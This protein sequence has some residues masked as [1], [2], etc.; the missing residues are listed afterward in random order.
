[1]LFPTT[2]FAVFFAIVFGVYWA[3][4]RF[5]LPRKVF[6]LGASVFFYAWWSW[7]FALMMLGVAVFNHF[8]ALR[9]APRPPAQPAQRARPALLVFAVA[10]NL[11]LLGIFK[12]AGFLFGSVLVPLAVPVC[13]IFGATDALLDFVDRVGPF[14]GDIILPIGISFY[15]FQAI[16]YVVDVAK[17]TC[18]PAK[19]YLDFANYLAFFPKLLAGPIVRPADLLPA[20]E[21]LPGRDTRIDAGRAATLIV[22]GLFKKMVLANFL[23]ARLVD[24]VFNDP[25]AFGMVDT[26]LGFWGYTLQ[27]YCDFSA[28]TDI[29]IGIA[30]LLGFEFPLNFNAPY[31][32]RT[33]QEFW[34][35]WHISLSTWLRDYLYI[36]FGGSRCAKWKIS[37]NLILTF[38]LGGLWHGAGWMFIL[39][40]AFHGVYLAL[41]RP[42]LKKKGSQS[43]AP[44]PST[45]NIRCSIFNI[46]QGFWMFNVVTAGWI[47]FRLG[48]GGLGFETL[49][50]FGHSL[51]RVHAPVTLL[52]GTAVLLMIL[53]FLV[54]FLDGYRLRRVWDFLNRLPA[55]VLALVFAIALTAV[56]ALGPTGVAPFIYFQF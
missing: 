8:L 2:A 30:I 32:S 46:L 41:E 27:I 56:L 3:L 36:P 52:T 38:L 43:Q 4:E 14:V 53:A 28:Y 34:R 18:R 21:N 45:F 13:R 23:A 29:A 1:M 11:L 44:L 26:L 40:G 39:W 48:T 55:V 42:F 47:L 19:S 49:A 25:S 24:P 37:R 51:A 5:P 17:G 22:G 9:L 54:Q 15:T 35:R 12:Y 33:L 6:L 16:S 10:A 50:G 20:M 31:F 7:K